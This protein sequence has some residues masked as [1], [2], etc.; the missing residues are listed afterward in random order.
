[1]KHKISSASS[2]PYALYTAVQVRELD[3]TAIE[4]FGIPGL[5]LMEKAGAAVF[6]VLGECWPRAKAITVVCGGG[7]NGGD[8]YVVARLAR[9]AG[10]DVAVLHLGDMARLRGD[11]AAMAEAY[12]R[13]GGD[14]EPFIR[15]PRRTDVIVDAIFGTG[16]D[17]EVTGGWSEAIEA[18]NSHRAPVLAV[19]IP[20]GLHADT[21]IAL[22]CAIEAKVTISFIG[23]KRGLFTAEGP[24]YAGK[25][26]F[27]ALDIPAGVYAR[28]IISARRVDW[29][30]QRQSLHPRHRSAHKGS[31]GHVLVVGGAPGYAGAARMAAEGAARSGAGLV[32]VATWPDHASTL[33]SGRPELMVHGVRRP[34]DLQRLIERAN[35]L[36]IG[37]GLGRSEL[38][39]EFCKA[40]LDSGRPLVLDADAL[41]W[42]SVEPRTHP[43]WVLTPHPGE[44]SRLLGEPTSG[45][46]GDR[47]RAVGDLQARYGGIVVLK[48]AGT[49]IKG[50]GER[51]AAVCSGGN[52]GMA[53]GGMG[54]VL[55]GL[56]G[57]LIAQGFAPED[58]ST[59]GVCLHAAAADKAAREGERGLLASD[60]FP[61]LRPLLNPDSGK[62]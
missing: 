26:I 13:A 60:L 47:F 34:A 30:Q 48:G 21:G 24:Q 18:I 14:A 15:L 54:D 17:R 25:V 56:I 55:A 32:S 62:C 27:D 29:A 49:L 53:T 38:A 7:N 37:P 50:P 3:R 28:Q 39:S 4:E 33:G 20:S 2:L 46:Q 42:L 36:V 58:A 6:R 10:L 57:G 45:I 12:R 31:Y 9:Q 41:Y 23:L 51:R 61:E 5:D 22:G 16:L 19:D 1:V 52:P 59:M 40:A 8:G 11:A 43:D 44:A 35:V